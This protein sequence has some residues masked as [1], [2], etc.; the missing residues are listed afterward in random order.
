MVIRIEYRDACYSM[1][2]TDPIPGGFEVRF[3]GLNF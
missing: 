3:G 1:G 2:S